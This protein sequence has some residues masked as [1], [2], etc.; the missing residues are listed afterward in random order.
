MEEVLRTSQYVSCR[1]TSQCPRVAGIQAGLTLPN[2]LS[3]EQVTL[4]V[5]YRRRTDFDLEACHVQI[6]KG[7]MLRFK[8]FSA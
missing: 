2:L 8:S 7:L 5:V 3:P 1:R 6:V 4:P